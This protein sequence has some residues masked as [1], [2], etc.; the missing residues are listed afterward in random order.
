MSETAIRRLA[1]K[2]G[3]KSPEQMVEDQANLEAQVNMDAVALE[4]NISTFSKKVD[5]MTIDGKILAYIQRP[6]K[7]QYERFVPQ[8]LSKYKDKPEE[9]P[10]NVARNYEE[11]IYKLMEELI[12]R[13]KHTAQEWKERVGDD[14]VAAFQAHMFEVRKR[15][16]EEASAFLRRT[17]DLTK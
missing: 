10:E 15:A 5:P 1:D 3:T 14:F 7:S 8:G 4:Q 6:N 16:T 13:P 17:T 11:D 2:Y 9:V 12:V